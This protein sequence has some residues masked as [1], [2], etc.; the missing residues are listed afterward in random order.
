MKKVFGFFVAGMCTALG[1]LTAVKLVEAASNPVKQA[2]VKKKAKNVI[3][4]FKQE[5]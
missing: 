1:Y 5:D 3:N 2:K 4:A